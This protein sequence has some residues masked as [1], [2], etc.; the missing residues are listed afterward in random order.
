MT[1]SMAQLLEAHSANGASDRLEL[2]H[3]YQLLAILPAMLFTSRPEGAWDYVNPQ[4]CAYAGRR[5]EALVGLG[6]VELLHIDDRASSLRAWQAGLWGGAPFAIEHR[7]RGA[8]GVYS[9]FRT[10]CA[11][12]R[13][14]VG[15]I[16]GWAGIAAPVESEHQVADERALRQSAEQARDARESVIAIV[17]HELRTPLT[18]LLGQAK[19]LQ[20]RLDAHAEI[21]PG[22]RRA[23]ATL[24]GQTVRLGELMGA[25]LDVTQIDHGLL[26]VSRA[27]LDLAAIVTRVV[28]ASQMAHPAHSLQLHIDSAPIW[29]AGDALRLEQVLQNLLQNAAKYSPA[30]SEIR[31]RLAPSGDQAQISV[32]DRGIGIAVDDQPALFQRFFRAGPRS[33]RS[34]AGLGLGLYICKAIMDLHCGTIAVESAEGEGCTVTLLL[35]R[36]RA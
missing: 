28:E 5:Q 10:Q 9:W 22:D 14:A 23:A 29:V 4:F 1:P 6:W 19:L 20:R 7:L 26:Q 11:P 13:N 18:V 36:S 33:G 3:D 30:G 24:V 25:L 32:S 16:R 12:Q 27:R 8:N 34:V 15:A 31:V 2:A 21:E 35:P 17:A